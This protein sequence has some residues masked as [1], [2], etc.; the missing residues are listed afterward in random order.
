MNRPLIVI[1]AAV[2]L[3]AI[4]IGLIFPILPRLL[5]DVTHVSN[6]APYVGIMYSLFA[7]IQGEVEADLVPRF[8]ATLSQGTRLQDVGDAIQM[9]QGWR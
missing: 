5:E 2:I 8:D 6:I 4:G 3:D 7:A 1:L 9:D